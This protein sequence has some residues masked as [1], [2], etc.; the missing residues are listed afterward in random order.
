M[1]WRD[2]RFLFFD[3]NPRIFAAFEFSVDELQTMV[4]EFSEGKKYDLTRHALSEL[5][6]LLSIYLIARD[7]S[8]RVPTTTMAVLFPSETGFD[9]VLTRQLERF[10]AHATRGISNSD[11]EFVK[12]VVST[13]ASVSL[14]SLKSRSYFAR[15]DENSVP[16]YVAAYL[17]GSIRDAAMRR[18][19]D[20]VL[21]GTDHLRDLC[22]ALIENRLYSSALS[23]ANSLEQL[24]TIS[25]LNTTDVV[26][27][28]AVR[29]ISDCLLHNCVYGHS[30]THIG[31]S[32]LESLF[33]I[34]RARLASPLGFE[35]MNVPYSVGPFISP[36]ERS[37]FAALN[38]AM[39]NRII[40]L[41]RTGKR[42]D[43]SRLISLY[44]ELHDRTWLDFAELGIEAVKKNSFLL[45]YINGTIE[46]TLRVN[47]FLVDALNRLPR[48][49]EAG[50][51]AAGAQH[52]RDRFRDELQ[53]KIKWE[54]TGVYSRIISAMFEHKQLNYLQGTIE[55]QSLFGF[56]ALRAHM[57]EIA[58]EAVERIFG[59]C[60]KLQDPQYQD[61]YGSARLATHIAKI[62]IY[63][64][65][66][67]S[68]PVFTAAKE[69]YATLRQTFRERFP[70]MYFV[71]DFD[72][73]ERELLEERR[74]PSI[75][76]I[77]PHDIEFFSTVTPDQIHTFFAALE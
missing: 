56:W 6:D 43:V 22:K 64:L 73:A 44:E 68:P 26:L 49:E 66:S 13:L 29:A 69:R 55:L 60:N 74:A 41:S 8:L 45:H 33:R 65:A 32:L 11:Q 25:I 14:A 3:R 36:T 57:E 52:Y 37:S 77:D 15:H 76:I 70:D 21:E 46:E 53:K 17:G 12:Q 5:R 4:F 39:A 67:D 71:G 9:G 40:D 23:Q 48:I 54:T 72:S 2:F 27:S 34:T 18:L 31:R 30:G 38:V 75:A 16:S 59:A 10:K 35:L 19:D 58:R 7:N 20:V 50:W 63:A 24:A 1:R 51:E 61:L 28:A 62:G 42:E 47:F